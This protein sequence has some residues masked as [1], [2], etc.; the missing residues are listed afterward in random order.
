[1]STSFEDFLNAEV[2]E[3]LRS[4]DDECRCDPIQRR[5]KALVWIE[6]NADSFRKSWDDIHNN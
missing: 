3:I 4:M 5:Q 6:E 2:N 1:M